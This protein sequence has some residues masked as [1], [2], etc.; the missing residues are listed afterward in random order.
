MAE[1]VIHWFR[2]D[3]RLHDNPA[4]HAASKASSCVIPVYILSQWKVQHRWTGPR[5][6]QFLCD[7]LDSLDQ[8]LRHRGARLV[9]RHGPPLAALEQ[10]IV[11]SKATAV[12]FNRDVDLFGA[13]VES[14]L[15]ALCAR[16]GVAC[17]DFKDAVLHEPS[18]I[19][20][21]QGNPYRVYTPYSR[22]W[23]TKEKT[24]CLGLPQPFMVPQGVTS[25][26]LPTLDWWQ[27]SVPVSTHSSLAAGEDAA[28]KRLDYAIEN[29]LAGYAEKRDLP[30]GQNTSRLSQDLRFG[31]LS[32]REI[33]HRVIKSMENARTESVRQSH[34]V[35]LKELAW[36]EFYIQI[37]HYCPEVLEHE[38]NP[39]YRQLIWDHDNAK[40][41]RW[42]SGV[43]GFPLVDAGMRE[44]LATGFMHNRVRMIVSMFLTK[45]LHIDWREGEKHFMQH[46]LDGEIASNNGGWQW[47][48]GTGA[49]AAP[50]FR[51]QNPWTQTK[52]FDPEGTYIKSWVPELRHLPAAAFFQAPSPGLPLARGYPLPMVDHATE[53][54]ET[55]ARFKKR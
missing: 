44:L 9:I 45:D 2:R 17:H 39:E 5:R 19:Q 55:L 18:E 12:Y 47:S 46:L 30:A 35:Y 15:H 43:T 16:L 48:A 50:Y 6:Q 7:C 53:R 27:L 29:V 13:K 20:T 21:Q 23:L 41:E 26:P 24:S 11:D 37:L 54:D 42:K 28:R 8:S 36:R 14:S 4:L 52:R 25:L 34:L 1:T 38:F 31:L 3:L 40:L 22:V 33:Y 10:L 49:D 51:I 32:I